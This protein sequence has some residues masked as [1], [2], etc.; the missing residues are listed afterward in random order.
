MDRND[1]IHR[2]DAAI[3]SMRATARGEAMAN[4]RPPSAAKPFCGD[5]Y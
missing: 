2:P 5:K 1:G 4:H 3:R